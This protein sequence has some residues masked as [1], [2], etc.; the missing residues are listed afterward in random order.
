METIK[1]LQIASYASV[2]AFYTELFHDLETVGVSSFCFASKRRGTES[3]INESPTHLQK[4]CYGK[5]AIPFLRHKANTI[6]KACEENVDVASYQL[7]HA[8]TLYTNG[9][10][11]YLLSKKYGI[12][13]IVT[14]R[15]VD[16]DVFPYINC[17]DKGLVRKT[18]QN[19]SRVIFVTP[20]LQ[21]KTE[22]LFGS[23]FKDPAFRSKCSVIPNKA[24]EFFFNNLGSPKEIEANRGRE[25]LFVG[26][27]TK[28]SL[29][30]ILMSIGIGN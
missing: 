24:S 29:L 7:L 16:T 21:K 18:L 15:N 2:D 10:P 23:L 26:R 5:L 19:A 12:P 3:K 14:I 22:R 1:V 8:H 30:G 6:A 9:V 17:F 4:E 27:L 20:L 11:A 25:V 28:K 13:Y